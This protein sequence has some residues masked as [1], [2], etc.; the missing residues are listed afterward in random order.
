MPGTYSPFSAAIFSE[1]LFGY[2]P[3][4]SVSTTLNV[5]PYNYNGLQ[6]QWV[7]PG[8]NWNQLVLVRSSFGTPARVN[9]GTQLLNQ[10]SNFSN[11]YVDT[12]LKSGYFYY[13]ALFVFDTDIQQWIEAAAGQGLVLTQWNF[14]GTFQ[15]WLPDF[16]LEQDNTLIASPQT[17]GPLVRFLNLL[18]YE[19]DWIRSEIESLFLLTNIDLISGMLLPYVAGNLGVKYEPVLGMSRSRVLLKNIIYL[20]QIKGTLLGVQSTASA[21]TGFGA[22]ATIGINLEIQLDDSAFDLSNGHWDHTVN[23][24]VTP[25]SAASIGVNPQHTAYSPPNNT[26]V[27][28]ITAT[29]PVTGTVYNLLSNSDAT[30]ENTPGTTTAL[31]NSVVIPST[32]FSSN[33]GPASFDG[34]YSLEMIAKT[35]ALAT[36]QT[37]P[38]AVTGSTAYTWGSWF[39]TPSGISSQLTY[40]QQVMASNPVGWWRFWEASGA[41]TVTDYGTGG[42]NLTTVEGLTFNQTGPMPNTPDQSSAFA[43]EAVAYASVTGT[44]LTSAFQNHDFTVELWVNIPATSESDLDSFFTIGASGSPATDTAFYLNIAYLNLT[45]F[46][47]QPYFAGD[48]SHQYSLSTSLL[49]QWIHVAVTW[50]YSTRTFILYVNGV[51]QGSF[52]TNGALNVAGTNVVSVPGD[53]YNSGDQ[54]TDGYFA[55]VAVYNSVLSSSTVLNHYNAG[56]AIFGGYDI[57]VGLDGTFVWYKLSEAVS[58]STVLDRSGNRR[59]ATVHGT[60]TFGQTGPTPYGSE[61]AALFNGSTGYVQW[62]GAP[63]STISSLSWETWYKTSNAGTQAIFDNGGVLNTGAGFGLWLAAGHL[64]ARFAGSTAATDSNTSNDGNWHQAVAVYNGS[65]LI[66]YRDGVQVA[67]VNYTGTLGSGGNVTVGATAGTASDF[68]NG[69]LAQASLYQSALSPSRVMEHYVSGA[70]AALTGNNDSVRTDITWYSDANG[71]V[72]ISTV[73]GTAVTDVAKGQLITSNNQG[74]TTSFFGAWGSATSPSNALSARLTY[75]ALNAVAGEIQYIDAAGIYQAV[76]G[77]E[78]VV[79]EDNPT[80]YWKLN[81]TGNPSGAIDWSGQNLFL[82]FHTGTSSTG[83]AGQPGPLTSYPTETAFTF[84]QNTWLT[85]YQNIANYRLVSLSAWSVEF[86]IKIPN[87]ISGNNAIIAQGVGG[88]NTGWQIYTKPNGSG[89][90]AIYFQLYPYNNDVGLTSVSFNAWHHVVFTYSGTTLT[91]YLD[92]S[93]AGSTTPGFSSAADTGDP[94]NIGATG[95]TLSSVS[96]AQVAMYQTALSGARVTA[97]YNAAT[98]VATRIAQWFLLG[99]QPP[100]QFGIS[101]STCSTADATVLGLPVAQQAT[102]PVI[103]LSGYFRGYPQATPTLST[104][105]AQLDWYTI[106]GAFISSTVGSPVTEAANAWSRA[107]VAASPPAGAEFFGRTFTTTTTQSAGTMHLFD[108][109]QVEVNTQATP[110]PTTWDPPRDIKVS[111]LPLRQNLITNPQGLAGSFGWTTTNC[112]LAL[113]QVG[114]FPPGILGALAVTASSAGNMIVSFPSIAVVPGEPYSWSAYLQAIATGRT[115]TLTE[116][117]YNSLN[118]LVGTKQTVGADVTGLFTRI[119]VINAIAPASASTA[120][121]QITISG[122]ANNEVH[123]LTGALFEPTSYLNSYFDGNF[124]PNGTFTPLSTTTADYFFEGPPNESI[125]DYYPNLPTKVNRLQEILPDFIPIGSTFT[126][127]YGPSRL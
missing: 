125:S 54:G 20:Y 103:V 76:I 41:S 53:Y 62:T 78:P 105:E 99:Q 37:G 21:Y 126:I 59:N 111:L 93:S 74:S 87:T 101:F 82:S 16:Y 61:T 114:P 47:I 88:Q 107:Y 14:T 32:G 34:A 7:L 89:A 112:S 26:N 5:S 71:T 79:L 119:S 58:S 64:N 68:F 46:I 43:N 31:A 86:W 2:P 98:Q 40:N 108:A 52:T 8:G 15:S 45:S 55:E 56:I 13:Y 75:N 94:F 110:G 117:F 60:V 73:T 91:M 65:K 11:S 90:A 122:A 115:V 36:S 50:A 118:A 102:P 27:G 85:T 120:T 44:A 38:Y 1:T 69:T 9:D 84:N 109:E 10:T 67:S 4:I 49:G 116:N 12:P 39:K 127:L 22:L 124:S 23:C 63:A 81:D 123:W 113:T 80:G 19:T 83:V 72:P 48:V 97:H 104:W 29:G 6:L 25:Q 121:A 66:L 42:N 70:L 35:T 3:N 17:Q 24:T 33:A 95:S 30:F 57:N 92:G 106:N 96:L 28:V 100:G 51:S 18:G 77:Y